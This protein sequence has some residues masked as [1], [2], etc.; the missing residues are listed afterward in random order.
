[1]KKVITSLLLAAFFAPTLLA[2]D[3]PDL[4]LK[5]SD[6]GGW[7]TNETFRMSRR[8][9]LY[10]IH[11]DNLSGEFK[12]S[13]DSWNINYGSNDNPYISAPSE[14]TGIKDAGNFR[15]DGL[16]NVDIE[17][18]YN[19]SDNTRAQITFIVD[20]RRPEGGMNVSGLSGS[21]P[22]LYINVFDDNGNLDNEVIDIN[23]SHKN[24]FKGQYWL[25][26]N[27]CEWLEAEG[28]KSIGSADEPLPLQIKARG[29][30][31]RTGFSKKPFKLKLDKKQSL[32]GLSKSKHF[33]ILA[34]ADDNFGYLRN[35]TGFNLGHRIGLP[36]TPSQQPV[37]VVINGDYRGLYFLTESIRVE[38]ERVN[39][40]ELEDGESDLN[41][42]SGGYLIELDNYDEDYE[43]QLQMPEKGD[44]PGFKD[45]LR[46]TF[47]TPEVYSD[48]QRMFIN[49]QFTMMNDLVGNASDEL[50]KYIDI[51]DLARYYIVCE[52][53]SHVEAFHGSTYMFRD[54]GENRKWHF[55]PL[56]DFGN[57]FN[58][59]SDGFIYDNAPYGMT[60]IG[61]ITYNDKFNEK[62]RETW[63]W[64]MSDRF[65]GIYDDMEKITLHLQDAAKADSRRW[66]GQ[67]VPYNG[68]PVVDNSDMQSRLAD[69]RRHLEQK[70]EWLKQRFGDYAG[71]YAE[72]QR[73]DTPAAPL[74]DFLPVGNISIT[75]TSDSDAAFFNLQ[76]QPV[77]NPQQGNIYIRV[78]EGA[79]T[80]VI[81]TH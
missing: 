66:N 20:G 36:W 2:D 39:I 19:L 77:A 43:S 56:W 71:V 57:A 53:L 24:Y 68:M 29:N 50:W 30:W 31:T 75:S 73:D 23:L 59:P 1:M 42:L 7:G 25:D 67:P 79:A 55:S 16:S 61:S 54:R 48:L 26:L 15:A 47:D 41:L 27:G 34:H 33:A 60:W 18:I 70:I 9:D 14:V 74:P 38:E 58:G 5:G 63:K 80:K 81:F 69:S 8:G 72:P 4:Y 46:V 44:Y 11:V 76:G 3:F 17:L 22:V 78:T 45:M 13:D 65:D 52:V 51:D 21:L 12:I 40:A 32:L 37:E 62:V 10:T 49:Q 35:F 28:A 6:Y 64:F